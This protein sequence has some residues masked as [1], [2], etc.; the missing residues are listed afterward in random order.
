MRAQ[1]NGVVNEQIIRDD[2]D[3]MLRLVRSLQEYGRLIKTLHILIRLCS[4]F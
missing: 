3:E 2:W 4:H 1:L